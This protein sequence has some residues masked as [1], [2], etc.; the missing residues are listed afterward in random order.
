MFARKGTLS[1]WHPCTLPLSTVG[2]TG[3]FAS[4]VV[5]QCAVSSRLLRVMGRRSVTP[6][7]V[8]DLMAL[9]LAQQSDPSKREGDDPAGRR[10]GR[11]GCGG[12]NEGFKSIGRQLAALAVD[13]LGARRAVRALRLQKGLPIMAEH[14]RYG[15]GFGTGRRSPRHCPQMSTAVEN[16]AI[17]TGVVSSDHRN[18]DPFERGCSYVIAPCSEGSW[19]P[20]E[21]GEAT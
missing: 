15:G 4:V 1:R 3:G 21:V 19:S 11:V 7:Q 17:A 13:P 9:A 6:P 18:G 14:C 2:S 8:L 5:R 12:R 20:A 10:P 16:E